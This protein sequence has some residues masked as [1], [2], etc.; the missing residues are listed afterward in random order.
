MFFFAAPSCL[1]FLQ[2]RREC[3]AE[4]TFKLGGKDLAK[5]V[6]YGGFFAQGAHGKIHNVVMQLKGVG[7]AGGK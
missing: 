7:E 1:L 3:K 2:L 6:E 5:L 4:V